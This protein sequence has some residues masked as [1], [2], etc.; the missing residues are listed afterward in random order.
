MGRIQNGIDPQLKCEGK[1]FIDGEE[2]MHAKKATVKVTINS[3]KSK[4]LGQKTS[5]TRTTGYDIKVEV[6]M[7]KTNKFGTKIIKDYI[8]KGLTPEFTIQLFNND[9]GSDFY[10]K[11]GNDVVTVIGCVPTGDI[12]L[13]D[14]DSSSTDYVEETI[15][16]DG[17]Q[18]T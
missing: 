7:Y 18:I 14:L 5:K 4:P 2:C 15:S 11:Y 3:N 6:G 13:M 17:Y 8:D 16:F 1:V 10:K 9:K 12:T